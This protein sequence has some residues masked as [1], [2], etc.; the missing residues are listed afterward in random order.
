MS[1]S[2]R[3]LNYAGSCG[4]VPIVFQEELGP[5][6]DGLRTAREFGI[7]CPI[8]YAADSKSLR[9][10]FEFHLSPAKLG[11]SCN[12]PA[13]SLQQLDAIPEFCARNSEALRL[14]RP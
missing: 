14:R 1:E 7:R 9:S 2:S 13:E 11:F 3:T 5:L 4:K 8:F 12:S 10:D 6:F